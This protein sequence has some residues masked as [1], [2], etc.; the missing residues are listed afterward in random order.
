[1]LVGAWFEAGRTGVWE[2]LTSWNYADIKSV[3]AACNRDVTRAAE[4]IEYETGVREGEGVRRVRVEIR[5]GAALKV[6][7]ESGNGDGEFDL[8]ELNQDLDMERG[9]GD[10]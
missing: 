2:G 7:R 10:V 1:L 8:G 4:M 9:R 3:M 6:V 5:G